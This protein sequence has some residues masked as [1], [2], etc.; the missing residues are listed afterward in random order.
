MALLIY[1]LNTLLRSV[2]CTWPDVKKRIKVYILQL[3]HN[4]FLVFSSPM[5]NSMYGNVLKYQ[6][7]DYWNLGLLGREWRSALTAHVNKIHLQW[8]PS[9]VLCNSCN[10]NTVWDPHQ[11]GVV[12]VGPL[13]MMKKPFEGK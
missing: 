13:K 10:H 12:S 9:K 8:G 11:Q 7:E 2:E 4:Y 6:L 3:S 5:Q 1:R